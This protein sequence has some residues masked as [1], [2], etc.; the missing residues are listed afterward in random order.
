MPPTPESSR[1]SS[2]RKAKPQAGRTP[3]PSTRTASRASL[4]NNLRSVKGKC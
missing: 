1:K 4:S 3:A 2:G